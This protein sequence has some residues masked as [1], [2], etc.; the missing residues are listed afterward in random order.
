MYICCCC[1]AII[2]GHCVRRVVKRENKP[3]SSFYFEYDD[4]STTISPW[5]TKLTCFFICF[6]ENVEIW[7]SCCERK[8]RFVFFMRK[9]HAKTH[10]N[11]NEIRFTVAN[12]VDQR[13]YLWKCGASRKDDH[14]ENKIKKSSFFLFW[15]IIIFFMIWNRKT[16]EICE[17]AVLNGFAKNPI[18]AAHNIEGAGERQRVERKQR[19]ELRVIAPKILANSNLHANLMRMSTN[20]R[21]RHGLVICCLH[22]RSIHIPFVHVIRNVCSFVFFLQLYIMYVSISRFAYVNVWKCLLKKNVKLVSP[23]FT[24]FDT[25][26]GHWSI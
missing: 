24:E 6:E 4:D 1:L 12:K 23:D 26:S 16:T 21:P 14:R 17:F 18:K 3:G 9:I 19:D 13:K 5:T 20:K 22:T 10:K 25:I 15:L 7:S 11:W 2:N 8:L